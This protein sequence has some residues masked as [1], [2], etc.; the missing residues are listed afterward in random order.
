MRRAL[1]LVLVALLVGAGT[2]IGF[3]V[4]GRAGFYEGYH[5]ATLSADVANACI[6]IGALRAQERGDAKG[7]QDMLELFVDQALIDDWA[8]LPPAIETAA[9]CTSRSI[10]RQDQGDE[11]T[12]RVPAVAPTGISPDS[13]GDG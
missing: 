13:K 3:E 2:F 1:Q 7:A 10:L 4:G 12:R 6:A 9:S 5:T 8:D 11:K